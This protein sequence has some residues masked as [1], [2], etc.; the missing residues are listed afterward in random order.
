MIKLLS[1]PVSPKTKGPGFAIF[2]GKF[3][4]KKAKVKLVLFYFY[5]S[6]SAS[7]SFDVR[8]HFRVRGGP[9]H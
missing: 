7:L 4:I 6:W 8:L 2:A 5:V 9:F 3:N 1:A